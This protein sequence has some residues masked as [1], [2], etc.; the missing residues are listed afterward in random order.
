MRIRQ[1][2][3]IL[4]IA[5]ACGLSF[6]AGPS[7]PVPPAAGGVFDA[8]VGN[9]GVGIQRT[10]ATDA[11]WKHE[12]FRMRLP[13]HRIEQSKL[14]FP[15]RPESDHRCALC[16]RRMSAQAGSIALP[17]MAMEGSPSTPL[18]TSPIIVT[19]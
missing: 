19:R 6:E 5:L 7:T 17:S 10:V 15:R 4:A 2:P 13:V 1:F 9:I 18:G 14:I 3:L 12:A 8:Q 16:R 11:R